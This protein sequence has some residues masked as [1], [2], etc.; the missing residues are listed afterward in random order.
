[1]VVVVEDK[2]ISIAIKPPVKFKKFDLARLWLVLDEC[3]VQCGG[4]DACYPARRW[5]Y[6]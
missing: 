1:M 3:R 5:G 4:R 2:V 6:K